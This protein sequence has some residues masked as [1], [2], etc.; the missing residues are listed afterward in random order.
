MVIMTRHCILCSYYES[1][2][3]P[4]LEGNIIFS[5]EKK[6]LEIDSPIVSKGIHSEC[7]THLLIHLPQLTGPA[8]FKIPITAS[9]K[10]GVR[11]GEKSIWLLSKPIRFFSPSIINE[12]HEFF[13]IPRWLRKGLNIDN[14]NSGIS[15]LS[16]ISF[17]Y[18]LARLKQILEKESGCEIPYFEFHKRSI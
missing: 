15:S 18:F 17:N 1:K 5:F 4:L 6:L 9:Y 8:L 11:E 3:E 7:L 14:D 2:K 13:F 10:N 12:N 16:P